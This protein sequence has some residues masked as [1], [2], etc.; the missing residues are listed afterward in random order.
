M[1]DRSSSVHFCRSMFRMGTASVT[2]S[3]GMIER[4]LL[5]CFVCLIDCI[6]C[7]KGISVYIG[8]PHHIGWN[9]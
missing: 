4:L 9:P 3:Y 2:T 5:S 6:C 7:I 1:K 8:E